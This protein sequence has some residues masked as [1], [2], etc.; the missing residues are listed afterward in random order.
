MET[1]KKK[2]CKTMLDNVLQAEKAM[3]NWDKMKIVVFLVVV[4]MDKYY[5]VLLVMILMEIIVDA[6]ILM[7]R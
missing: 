4:I 5:W 2:E 1:E 6:V 7:S 3:N